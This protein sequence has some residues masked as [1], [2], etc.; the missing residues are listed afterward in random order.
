M[1]AFV[2]VFLGLGI[3]QLY[4]S[5]ADAEND[6]R[7][8]AQSGARVVAANVEWMV[9]TA[10]QV[11]RRVDDSI[12]DPEDALPSDA[13]GRLAEAVASIP[14]RPK[15]YVVDAAGQTLLTTDPEYKSASITDREY[16]QRAKA[17]EA[18]WVSSLL[19][20]RQN[21]EQI[22]TISKRMERN[23]RFAGVVILSFT[24]SLLEKVWSSLA[25]DPQSTVGL[26]R[27]DGWLVSRFPLPDGPQDLSKYVLFTDYLPASPEGTYPATSPTD[28]VRRLVAYQR[29]PGTTLIALSSM[30]L[31]PAMA[32][33]QSQIAG[34]V[35]VG[36]PVVLLLFVIVGWIARLLRIEDR[37]KRALA[38]AVERNN[39]LLREIHHRVKNHLTGV[40]GLIN[41]STI[42]PEEK[43]SL[44][45]R[46]GAMVSAYTSTYEQGDHFDGLDASEYIPRIVDDLAKGYGG[47]VEVSYDLDQVIVDGNKAMALALVVNEV[48]TNAFKYAFMPGETGRL[49]IS[50]K[51]KGE[52]AVLTIRDSGQGYD[53]DTARKGTGSRLV[54]GFA[55]Q[56][57]GEIE[58]IRDGGTVFVL[59]FRPLVSDSADVDPVPAA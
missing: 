22:F 46:I 50:L 17:G 16:F 28:G 10:R 14:G 37:Q 9:E 18:L 47:T 57:E 43:K 53:I 8:E 24:S 35:A 38:A 11:L 48:V 40:I 36:V 34:R 25:L 52:M 27:D 41:V 54:R 3:H 39:L 44:T 49:D 55:G 30:A 7:L 15:V 1:A 12:D 42:I 23:G 51:A 56:L 19:V 31:E 5:Y 32:N 45:E 6:V 58:V 4:Q 33:F 20:S 29:V 2:A 59:T 26:F 13:A 21:G